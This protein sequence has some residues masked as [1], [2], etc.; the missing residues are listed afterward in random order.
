MK[1]YKVCIVYIIFAVILHL[2]ARV[3]NAAKIIAIINNSVITDIDIEDF[4]KNFCK[5]EKRFKCGSVESYNFSTIVLIENTLKLEHFKQSG[6]FD[7]KSMNDGFNNYK[8]NV[9]KN[10][11]LRSMKLSKLFN[12]YLKTEYLWNIVISSQIKIED[13]T[14]NDI[15]NFLKEK[16]IRNKSK[17]EARQLLLIEK[18]NN[19]SQNIFSELKKIYFVDFKS[20]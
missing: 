8:K 17:D 20:L 5:L 2:S 3:C 11:K 4:E 9:L 16:N 14:D 18:M 1:K 15:N 13:I 7:D 10:T 12:D 6:I 19:I